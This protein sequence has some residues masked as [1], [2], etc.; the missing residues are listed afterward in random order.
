MARAAVRVLRGV[1]AALPAYRRVAFLLGAVLL[2]QGAS[3]GGDFRH[4]ARAVDLGNLDQALFVER[5]H[6]V[7]IGRAA[8]AVEPFAR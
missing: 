6:R 1:L 7:G 2:K 3:F 5:K 8:V 4:D